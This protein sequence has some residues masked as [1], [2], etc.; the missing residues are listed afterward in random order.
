MNSSPGLRQCPL[1]ER[2]QAVPNNIAQHGNGPLP[3]VTYVQLRPPFLEDCL[4]PGPAAAN[5]SYCHILTPTA[6]WP[7]QGKPEACKHM[8]RGPRA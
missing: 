2:L 7:K 8:A 3:P 1:P 6:E 5:N 4:L